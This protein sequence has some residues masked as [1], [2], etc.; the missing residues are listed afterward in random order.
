M[1]ETCTSVGT[2]ESRK[3]AAV[4]VNYI[5]MKPNQSETFINAVKEAV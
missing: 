5:L 4:Y 1:C 2:R 3:T